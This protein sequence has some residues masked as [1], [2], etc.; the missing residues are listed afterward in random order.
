MQETWKRFVYP[1]IEDRKQDIEEEPYHL[2]I[3]N[4]LMLLGWEPWKNEI[5][6]KQSLRIGNRNRMEPD[7]LI[8]RD[9]EYQF[10]IEVKRPG[11][12]QIKEEITQLESYMRQL[13][14]CVGIYIGEHIEVF[15][16]KPNTNHV[17][18]V[19][20]LAIDLEEKRGARFVELFSKEGFS[21]EGI[22]NFCEERL[23]EIQRQAS[24]N[25]IKESLI[26][27]AQTQI[28]ESLKPYL[29][30]KYENTFSEDDIMGM[31]SRLMFTAKDVDSAQT[32]V[33]AKQK[34]TIA[35]TAS[36]DTSKKRMY[37]YTEY[38]LDG[39]PF[40][41]KNKFVYAVV[42]DYVKHHPE[43]TF[44]E[45]ERVF[46]PMLQ[47]SFGVVRTLEYIKEKNYNGRRYFNEPEFVLKDANGI[48]FAVS[49]EWG[50]SNIEKFLKAV[51]Q[52]GCHVRLSTEDDLSEDTSQLTTVESLGNLQDGPL[53]HLYIRDAKAHA[54]FNETD[55]SMRIL[56]GSLLPQSTVSSYK[57]GNKR[58]A[59][60]AAMS[61]PTKD[62]FW[63][64]QR[65]YVL[66][67][68]STAASYCSGRSTNGWKHWVN[69]AG[70]SLD[71]LYWSE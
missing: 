52:I 69:D 68:P 43:A 3:E 7:I 50:K 34:D 16:D 39:G 25:K 5:I 26:A 44:E 33:D 1:L 31:L 57:D 55:H 45:I 60:I 18:S 17:V 6:H 49:T 2:H 10:V 64:L 29:L 13:R 42:T 59:I 41:G 9:G 28:T 63:E 8:A 37:D 61:K 62:G 14:L 47:G 15:Y 12:R 51:R 27:D 40:L 24:L 66:N 48:P 65:D 58:N 54:I 11:N 70:Q 38:S 36:V 32:V 20:K 19:F 53:F 30:E 4:Q 71:D 67:S 46:P 22:V 56:K 21:K 35:K 23:Q